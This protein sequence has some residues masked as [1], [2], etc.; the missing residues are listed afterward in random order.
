MWKNVSTGT[1]RKKVT[2]LLQNAKT[3]K[4]PPQLK[5]LDGA[6]SEDVSDSSTRFNLQRKG[7]KEKEIENHDSS[8]AS[9]FETKRP[10]GNKNKR[11]RCSTSA[12]KSSGQEY[13][14][15]RK[16][17]RKRSTGSSDEE[18]E[19]SD[20]LSN[21]RP[22]LRALPEKECITDNSL[23]EEDSAPAAQR[24]QR[25][26]NKRVLEPRE[27]QYNTRTSKKTSPGEARNPLSSKRK[28][29][30]TSDSEEEEDGDGDPV[31]QNNKHSRS[32][33]NTLCKEI[34]KRPVTTKAAALHLAPVR[35]RRKNMRQP[36][37]KRRKS[38]SSSQHSSDSEK[39]QLSSASENFFSS[40]GSH[41][42]PKR[43]ARAGIGDRAAGRQLRRRHQR[44]ASN[45]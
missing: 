4:N 1:Q 44:A 8:D 27:V 24:R 32:N 28:R 42:S 13:K 40:S 29:I 37:P 25:N 34:Q 26:G 3:N 7:V 39:E 23:S 5:E 21:G 16:V 14:P 10:T 19:H 22:R 11:L 45:K 2:F 36:K 30:Y 9:D 17:R 20:D 33:S 35:R 38:Y 12:S 31:K 41:S 15:S 43:R 6:S 18:S